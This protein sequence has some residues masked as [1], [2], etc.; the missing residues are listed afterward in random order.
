MR[1]LARATEVTDLRW[2]LRVNVSHRNW[3][4]LE[5]LFDQLDGCV[6]PERCTIT[7]AWVGDAGFGYD[8]ALSHSDEVS[9]RFATW[10][11]TALE[12]G[13]RI[14][15]PAMKMA[16]H[17][18]SVPGGRYGAVVNADGMLYSC[19]QSAGKRGFEV[20][21]IHDGYLDVSQ[22][23]N[24]WVSCGYEFAQADPAIVNEFQDRVDGR[25]LDYLYA[26]DRL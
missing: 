25:V 18:C 21:T 24:R 9:E 11:I 4:R 14:V 16:C 17:I 26:T 8:N 10:T 6:D 5:R 19:W 3:S 7:F 12:A 2:T 1:N 23:R 13:F 15:R 22:V 20:G